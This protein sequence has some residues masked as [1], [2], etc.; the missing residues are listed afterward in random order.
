MRRLPALLI[1]ALLLLPMTA[2]A[3]EPAIAAADAYDVH[4]AHCASV[5]GGSTQ[6]AAE[7]MAEV[8]EVWQRVITAYEASGRTYLLYWRGVLGEC[9]GQAERAA[10]DLRLFID[11]EQFGSDDMEPLVQ[12]AR[13]RLRRMGVDVDRPS[14]DELT[15]ARTKAD[16]GG[17]FSAAAESQALKRA[18]SS[19]QVP[20]FLVSGGGGYQRT[21]AYNYV[22]IAADLS[23]GIVGPLRAEVSYRTGASLSYTDEA[24]DT[25]DTGTYWLNVIGVGPALEFAGS[26]V[27]ARVGSTTATASVGVGVASGAAAEVGSGVGVREPPSF[28]AVGAGAGASGQSITSP[29]PSVGTRARF[30]SPNNAV[31]GII[32]VWQLPAPVPQQLPARSAGGTPS[33]A[34]PARPST[35]LAASSSVGSRRIMSRSWVLRWAGS[36]GPRG[37]SP[38]APGRLRSPCA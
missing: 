9:L 13:T 27:G 2:S 28:A 4:Q 16:A 29:Q 3:E 24:G 10:T 1:G 12:D 21:G 22:A 6:A 38:R 18:R 20:F 30:P 23:F 26:G 25:Q 7:S 5:A 17:E 36:R 31:R 8:T 19:A 14:D 32:A 37:G 11:L 33:A 35:R 15:E 34:Q